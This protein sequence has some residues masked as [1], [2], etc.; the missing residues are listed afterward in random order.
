MVKQC[1]LKGYL[2]VGEPKR[3]LLKRGRLTH[4]AIPCTR[5]SNSTKYEPHVYG[6]R[7]MI[8]NHIRK[9]KWIVRKSGARQ[10][11]QLIICQKV[12]IRPFSRG[13]EVGGL[14][15]RECSKKLNFLRLFSYKYHSI[16][17]TYTFF[18]CMLCS[19]LFKLLSSMN[20]NKIKKKI[21][22]CQNRSR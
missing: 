8:K 21:F 18:I 4:R 12:L 5:L 22:N 10:I 16:Q 19:E 20:F 15:V 7:S 14:R 13:K 11:D 17:S 6:R 3:D 1:E 2:I 9:K